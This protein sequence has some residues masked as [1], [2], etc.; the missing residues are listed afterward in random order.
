RRPMTGQFNLD[1]RART[2]IAGV[3][4]AT[5][6]GFSLL[7]LLFG[8][9]QPGLMLATDDTGVYV[10]EV[11]P[12]GQAARDGVSEG[13]RVVNLNGQQLIRL[14]TFEYHEPDPQ[15]PEVAP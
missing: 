3:I 13:L 10:A 8:T 12:F 6:L 14:P 7:V 11:D 5:A 2:R 15:N 1:E 4:A 9:Y